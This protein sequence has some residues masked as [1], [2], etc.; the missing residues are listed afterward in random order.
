MWR[1]SRGGTPLVSVEGLGFECGGGDGEA[2]HGAVVVARKTA[3]WRMERSENVLALTAL[4]GLGPE[5][6]LVTTQ[7]IRFFYCFFRGEIIRFHN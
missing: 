1:E 3:W 7:I 6:N 5:E 2:A 4:D